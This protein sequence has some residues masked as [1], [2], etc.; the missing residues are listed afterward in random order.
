M[1][2]LVIEQNL[3]AVVFDENN[4][5]TASIMLSGGKLLG[6][7]SGSFSIKRGTTIYTYDERGRQ[8]SS[9]IGF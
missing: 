3:C 5:Q 9:K 4:R 2:S 6:Y 8:I 7:T 1:I